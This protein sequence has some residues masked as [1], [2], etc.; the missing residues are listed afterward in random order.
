M[1]VSNSRV[2]NCES[3]LE[4]DKTALVMYARCRWRHFLDQSCCYL[5][6]NGIANGGEFCDRKDLDFDYETRCRTTRVERFHRLS[7][8][9]DTSYRA[10]V[11]K[12]HFVVC[13]EAGGE[14]KRRINKQK[15]G[16]RRRMESGALQDFPI[17]RSVCD[18]VYL[19]F[20]E[21]LR[22]RNCMYPKTECCIVGASAGKLGQKKKRRISLPSR[23]RVKK[24]G[25]RKRKKQIWVG[26]R[27]STVGARKLFVWARIS[28]KAGKSW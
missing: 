17:P 8:C 24:K 21:M 26:G 27:E 6:W 12:S 23:S 28:R 5:S 20:T 19:R 13:R 11:G 22:R 25:D 7:V 18:C 3:L 4:F 2:S 10:D 15:S 16:G 9:T 1:F 14:L